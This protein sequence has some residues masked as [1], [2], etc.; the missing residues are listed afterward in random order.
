MKIALSAL[1]V[2]DLDVYV[3]CHANE[4]ICVMYRCFSENNVIINPTI[5][6]SDSSYHDCFLESHHKNKGTG[7]WY[8]VCGSILQER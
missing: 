3:P 8:G 1:I 7:K 5:G 4:A 2:L 6:G